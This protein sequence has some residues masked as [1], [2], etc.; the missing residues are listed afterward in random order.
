MSA[1]TYLCYGNPEECP[2]C[3]GWT[4]AGKGRDRGPFTDA[5]G[6]DFCSEDCAE[7]AAMF[8]DRGRRQAAKGWCPGCGYD[9]NEHAPGCTLFSPAATPGEPGTV[10]K[11][12]ST[13]ASVAATS[14]R[15]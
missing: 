5:T 2:N 14:R 3:G 4:R 9:N 1:I 15:R 6:E 7:E 11:S 13:E 8:R 10:V 12:C